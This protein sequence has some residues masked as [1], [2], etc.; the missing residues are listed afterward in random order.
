[1][2]SV[3][4]IHSVSV[5]KQ[6]VQT[7]VNFLYNLKRTG[8]IDESTFHRIRSVGACP[9]RI[10]GLPKTHKMGVPLRPIVSCVGT[11]SYNLAQYLVELLQPF[12]HNSFTVKDSFAFA[13]EVTTCS[14]FPFMASFDVT[15]LFTCV[16]LEEVIN[17]CLDKL[18]ANT[19]TMNNL[20][21]T[22]LYKMLSFT[23]KQNHFLFDG[24]VYNQVDGVA[25][26]SPLGPVMA[27]IFMCELERKA[28]EQYNGTLPSLYRRYV[29]DTFLVFNTRSDMLSFFKWM[30]KQHPSITFTKEEEQDN[31]LSFL[32]VLLTRTTDGSIVTSIYRKPTFSGLYMKWDSFVP[33]SYK[34]GLVNCLVFRAWKLCSSYVLFHSEILFVKELLMSNGYPANFIDSIV[35]RFLSKQFSNTDVIQPYGPHKRRVYL[36]L[37]Y[38]GE[39]ATNKFARQIRRLIAKIAPCVELRL[40]FRAAQKLSCLTRLKSKLN[41]LS[42][43]GVVSQISC[44]QCEAFYVGK[45]K[46]RLE[47]RVQE[48]SQQ[49]YSSLYKHSSDLCHQIDYSNPA[50]ISVDNNDYRL[51]IK[52]AL[53]IKDLK[54][55]N[56]LNANIRSCELKLW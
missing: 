15:S 43:S 34:K 35:H 44:T 14:S 7:D 48:H 10:Y 18:F 13:K 29:D 4:V 52:E 50:V 46:H 33:K 55:Y 24:K 21:R 20:N 28:L 32:D 26:G 56:S 37:P 8:K 41:V 25:M 27:N 3:E 23:L 12:S 40:V 1:M 45:T 47:Q 17:I 16:P 19:N 6:F 36:C 22:Q 30:N 38:V 53:K 31:K 42:R 2:C 5:S 54:A 39:L 51:Q 11:Y 49:G 9:G